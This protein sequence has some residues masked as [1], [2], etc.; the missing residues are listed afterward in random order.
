MMLL[1]VMKCYDYYMFRI[2]SLYD[3][4]HFSW[5][6]SK[7]LKRTERLC[8]LAWSWSPLW[9]L[10]CP[11]AKWRCFIWDVLD[12]PQCWSILNHC[13]LRRIFRTYSVFSFQIWP[14]PSLVFNISPHSD[15][16]SLICF[17][18]SILLLDWISLFRVFSLRFA[19][20]Y[21]W[22]MMNYETLFG[23]FW[24]IFAHVLWL[25]PK[26][27]C[28]WG[29]SNSSTRDIGT[30]VTPSHVASPVELLKFVT[31]RAKAHRRNPSIFCDA[32]RKA[33]HEQ[34]KG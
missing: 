16:L 17:V 19:I 33:S 30:D 10:L 29:T 9:P 6:A 12:C 3:I 31:S 8:A 28:V 26:R 27:S 7:L 11:L 34:P 20:A 1:H 5:A 13:C 22:Y 21:L 2:Y 18:S 14:G 32:G 4:L 24:P 15:S 23:S 25:L